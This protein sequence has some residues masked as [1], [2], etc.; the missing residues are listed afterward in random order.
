MMDILSE[1]SKIEYPTSVTE[2]LKLEGKRSVQGV[3]HFINK[4]P[5]FI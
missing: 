5:I 2:L 3:S 4:T 1:N